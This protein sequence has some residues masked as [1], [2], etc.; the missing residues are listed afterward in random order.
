MS[1]GNQNHIVIRLLYQEIIEKIVIKNRQNS[2]FN[3]LNVFSLLILLIFLEVFSWPGWK[4]SLLPFS[5][6]PLIHHIK[7]GRILIFHPPLFK[8]NQT[9]HA[10]KFSEL[11]LLI[12]FSYLESISPTHAAVDSQIPVNNAYQS[13]KFF[14]N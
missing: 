6:I 1:V 5:I 4:T 13:K 14:C 3:K 2:K 9:D 11:I 10:M 12:F 7:Q 8:P